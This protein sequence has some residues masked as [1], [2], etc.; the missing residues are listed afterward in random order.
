MYYSLLYGDKSNTEKTKQKRGWLGKFLVKNLY[1]RKD[2]NKF[3]NL[4][5]QFKFLN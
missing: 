1:F 3:L 4:F 5:M 2:L